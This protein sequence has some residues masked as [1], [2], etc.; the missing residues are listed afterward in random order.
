VYGAWNPV[1]TGL[2]SGFAALWLVCL[3]DRPQTRRGRLLT[4]GAT[5]VLLLA[6]CFTTG[7]AMQQLWT[8][9]AFNAVMSSIITIYAVRGAR[10]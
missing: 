1:S 10:W 6:V 5:M 2:T 4:N 3:A 7:S 9:V 8:S